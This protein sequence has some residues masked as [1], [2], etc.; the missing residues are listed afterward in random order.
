[1][2]RK[3]L[4]LVNQKLTHARL[5]LTALERAEGAT[6]PAL[7]EAV[8]GHLVCAYRHY[9]RELA[10]NYQVRLPGSI[11]SEASLSAALAMMD[12]HPSEAQELA[13]LRTLPSSWVS[14]M[15]LT[16]ERLWAYPAQSVASRESAGLI[17]L[18]PLEDLDVAPLSSGQLREWYEKFQDMLQRHRET[19]AEW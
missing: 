13:D 2:S 18:V 8:V 11:H 17:P 3:S 12:K 6:A 1:M 4:T 15:H 19:S 10:E 7:A 9:L 16:Y 14:E 5:L